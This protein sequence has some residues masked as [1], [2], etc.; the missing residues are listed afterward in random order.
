[1]CC[2][3]QG[4]VERL[5]LSTAVLDDR[6]HKCVFIIAVMIMMILL[7]WT[8][9]ATYGQQDKKSKV[10]VAVKAN[11]NA[12]D[13]CRRRMMILLSEE[14]YDENDVDLQNFFPE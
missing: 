7:G 2:T 1:M 8:V 5:S 4:S 11:L 13:E 3:T 14:H 6:S 12:D 9:Q 10:I